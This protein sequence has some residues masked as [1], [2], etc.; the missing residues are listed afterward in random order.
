MY[1][2]TNISIHISAHTHTHTQYKK[3][4]KLSIELIQPLGDK[5]L[6][7]CT[8]IIDPQQQKNIELNSDKPIV[9]EQKCVFLYAD[10]CLLF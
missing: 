2:R 10:V 5:I 9:S 3:F 1:T 6:C 7:S 4:I 8:N